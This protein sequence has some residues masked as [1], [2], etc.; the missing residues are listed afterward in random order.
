MENKIKELQNNIENLSKTKIELEDYKMKLEI[1]QKDL[2]GKHAIS[3]TELNVYKNDIQKL[4][5]DNSNLN[6]QCFKQEK[7]IT[8]LQF[9]NQNY[10]NEIEEK[11]KKHRKFKTIS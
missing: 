1:N 9:K 8:E 11:K 10:L 2:E 4:R 3:N 7:E 5:E 6:Q